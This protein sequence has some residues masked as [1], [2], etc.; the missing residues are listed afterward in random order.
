VPIRQKFEYKWPE[1]A[2]P[3]IIDQWVATL[4]IEQQIEFKEA[5]ARQ[6]ASRQ[7]VINEG[8]LTYNSKYHEYIWKD[9]ESRKQDKEIDPVWHQYFIRFLKE[10]NI[11]FID[12]DTEI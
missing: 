9:T 12:T 8:K 5:K 3:M 11:T 10:N 4:P 7:K 6:V 1:G 2:T